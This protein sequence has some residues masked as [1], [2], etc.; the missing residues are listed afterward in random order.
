MRRFFI[1]LAAFVLAALAAAAIYNIPAVNDRLS[2]RV[3]L[4]ASR[5]RKIIAPQPETLP[6]PSY[7]I[8]APPTFAIETPANPPITQPPN[9]LTPQLPSADS[10]TVTPEPM[11]LPLVYDLPSSVLLEASRREPQ[12]QNNCGAATLVGDL[13]YWGWQGSEPDAPAWNASGKDIRW[14]KDI[15]AVIKPGGGVDKNLMPYELVNYAVDYAGLN[16]VIRYGGDI[17]TLRLFVANGYPVII[18][19]G[20]REEEHQL[21]GEG[22]EGHYGYVKGYD[23]DQRIAYTQDSFKWQ[24]INYPRPYDDL[25]RDWRDFNYVYIILYSSSRTAEVTALLGPDADPIANYNHALAK[26]QAETQQLTD[27]TELAF[28]WFN[29]GT[30]LTLLERYADAAAAFDQARSYGALPWRMLWYQTGMYKAYYHS[31]R[32]QDVI[33]LAGVTLQTPGLEESYYW[34][35]WAYYQMGNLG[36]AVADM[37]AALDTHPAWDQALAALAQWG[38]NP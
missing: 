26:A 1:L 21:A 15:A 3:E 22:W 23:D 31:G 13:T 6:T 11:P 29:V 28:A 36:G 34:R 4:L 37:R 30:S 33:D 12:L 35:G 25:L 27:P 20:F 5:V 17:D 8:A 2:W 10:P 16:A 24:D 7:P 19:R 38:L 18:E 32:Y 14:Q 9:S